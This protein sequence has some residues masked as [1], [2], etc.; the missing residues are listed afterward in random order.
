MLSHA[1]PLRVRVCLPEPPTGTGYRPQPP[2]SSALHRP[3]RPPCSP[4][5]SRQHRYPWSPARVLTSWRSFSGTS[6]EARGGPT[7]LGPLLAET[8]GALIRGGKTAWGRRQCE[9]L[10]STDGKEHKRQRIRL[11]PSGPITTFKSATSWEVVL[12]SRA[13]VGSKVRVSTR[14]HRRNLSLCRRAH[15]APVVEDGGR[16]PH[17][18]GH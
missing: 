8:P 2:M 18:A 11:T 13:F 5:H 12:G 9:G 16:G 4:D 17:S 14:L 3:Q 15:L 6:Y 7:V 1:M 10:Y